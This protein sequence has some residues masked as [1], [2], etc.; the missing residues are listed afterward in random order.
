MEKILLAV[1]MAAPHTI[2]YLGLAKPESLGLCSKT[3]KRSAVFYDSRF[4][5]T[6]FEHISYGDGERS[7]LPIGRDHNDRYL[8]VI[9]THD[10]ATIIADSTA[11]AKIA[12]L[13]GQAYHLRPTHHVQRETQETWSEPGKLGFELAI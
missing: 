9:E 11:G 12:A 6:H 10:G 5:A 7:P 13:T 4:R 1:I 8:Y 2:S 3:F